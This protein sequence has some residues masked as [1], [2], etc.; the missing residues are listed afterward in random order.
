[1]GFI[2]VLDAGRA[3]QGKKAH[4]VVALALVAAIVR[5]PLPAGKAPSLSI[6]MGSESS[7]RSDQS[8]GKPPATTL[9]ASRGDQLIG[10]EH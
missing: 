8:R 5:S 1:M 10:S 4:L 7:Q 3:A 9:M 2:A 6:E